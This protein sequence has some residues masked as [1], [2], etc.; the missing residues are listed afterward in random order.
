[1]CAR[2]GP[3]AAAFRAGNSPCENK[4]TDDQL[5]TRTGSSRDEDPG[6]G[7]PQEMRDRDLVL[8][9]GQ[10]SFTSGGAISSTTPAGAFAR[11]RALDNS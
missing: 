8:E 4:T 10:L 9:V 11:S 3:L 1:M 7:M 2:S 6:L 5:S